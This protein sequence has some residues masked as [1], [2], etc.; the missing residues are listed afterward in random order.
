MDITHIEHIGIAVKDIEKA[1]EYYEDVLGFECYAVE[2]VE[3]QKVKTA[4][5]YG[6]SNQNR[7]FTGNF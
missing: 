6:R 5:F 4:F 3:D 2:E 7:A 1:K